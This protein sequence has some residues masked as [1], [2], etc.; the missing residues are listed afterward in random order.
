MFMAIRPPARR[1][2]YCEAEHQQWSWVQFRE[3]NGTT[4]VFAIAR[5]GLVL[6][7]LAEPDLEDISEDR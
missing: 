7:P 6:P 3:A 4:G 2:A 1:S 5:Q